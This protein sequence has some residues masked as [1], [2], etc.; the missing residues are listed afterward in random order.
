MS[1]DLASIL[2]AT[3]LYSPGVLTKCERCG[4]VGSDHD[5]PTLDFYDHDETVCWECL[6]KASSKST[7]VPKGATEQ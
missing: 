4:K 7:I 6:D 5:I 3:A 1:K 2:Q